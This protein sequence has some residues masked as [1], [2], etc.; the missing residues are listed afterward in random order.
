MCSDG[1]KTMSDQPAVVNRPDL[2]NALNFQTHPLTAKREA[3]TKTGPHTAAVGCGVGC[4]RLRWPTP[5]VRRGTG[6]A[7]RRRPQ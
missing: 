6:G 3:L 7:L 2:G 4:G 1:Q 5:V